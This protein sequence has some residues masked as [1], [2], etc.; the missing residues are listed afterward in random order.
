MH[1]HENKLV[2]LHKLRDNVYLPQ[3]EMLEK[4][5]EASE[6]RRFGLAR[7]GNEAK[8]RQAMATL[9]SEIFG[10]MI[11]A[12][13][14]QRDLNES[15]TKQVQ[16]AL[17]VSVYFDRD[18]NRHLGHFADLVRFNYA[19]LGHKLAAAEQRIES[20]ERSLG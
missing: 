5:I 4:F 19:Y 3:R 20:I 11:R 1:T 13:G 8:M 14:R 17:M 12:Y 2:T 15:Q 7:F 18:N 9:H 6:G 10:D 16:R